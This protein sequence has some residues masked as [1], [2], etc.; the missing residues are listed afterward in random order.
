MAVSYDDLKIGIPRLVGALVK[1]AWPSGESD[2][3]S[4]L[5]R[6][7]LSPLPETRQ[8]RGHICSGEMRTP[9]PEVA[10]HWTATGGVLANIILFPY[11]TIPTNREQLLAAFTMLD[12]ELTELFGQPTSDAEREG[13]P[14][15]IWETHD[16]TISIDCY[17]SASRIGVLQLTI[18]RAR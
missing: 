5:E 6:H 3:M 11:E 13:A 18:E 9:F 15:R 4:F 7:S 12:Y 2:A 16:L 8:C 10:G 1:E 14:Q 17:W